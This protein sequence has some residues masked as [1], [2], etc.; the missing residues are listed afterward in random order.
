M[1]WLQDIKVVLFDLDGT[2][3]Q[4]DT[5]YKRYLGHLLRE[6]EYEGALADVTEEVSRILSGQHRCRIGDWYHPG[7]KVWMRLFQEQ[8]AVA[9]DWSGTPVEL[10]LHAL[11][12]SRKDLIYAGDAWSVTDV[13]ASRLQIREER[14]RDAF[15]RVREEM[16]A[17][18][19][20]RV[21]HPELIETIHGLTKLRT[22]VLLTNSP[23]DTGEEFIRALGCEEL[24]DQIHYAADKP[25]GIE[26]FVRELVKQGVAAPYQILSIG[27]HAWND[28]HPIRKLGGRTAWIAP[29]P[30]S[31]PEVWDVTITGV[32]ELT[33]FLGQLHEAGMAAAAS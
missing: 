25:K 10:D 13:M 6:T 20:G 28:L 16:L 2:L 11:E 1:D 9:F 27:D 22:K 15:Y 32:K 23:R 21:K 18:A 8:R 19:C 17:G 26:L 30:S 31:D 7:R 4:D 29:Y 24:F 3:Y 33:Q 14:R 5:F 12:G